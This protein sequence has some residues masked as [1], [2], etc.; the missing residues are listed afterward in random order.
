MSLTPSYSAGD[1]EH[2]HRGGVSFECRHQ[3]RAVG[4]DEDRRLHRRPLHRQIG[5]TTNG[6][7]A[8]LCVVPVRLLHR[9]PE[10]MPFTTGT[11]MTTAGTAIVG[12]ETCGIET[13]DRVL[14]YGAGAIGLLTM[15]FARFLGAGEVCIVDTLP[16]RLE[17]AKKLGAEVTKPPWPEDNAPRQAIVDE[18]RRSSPSA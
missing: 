4:S 5:M 10:G 16:S 14:I 2:R 17:V 8:Q 7:F 6:G 13:G 12:V 15:Q 9:L 18:V 11:L 3:V 1:L